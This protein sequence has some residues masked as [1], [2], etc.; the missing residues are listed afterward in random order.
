MPCPFSSAALRLFSCR[1]A[2]CWLAHAL[3]RALAIYHA[4]P[5]LA[6]SNLAT[7]APHMALRAHTSTWR[8]PLAYPISPL[9]APLHGANSRVPLCLAIPHSRGYF[10]RKEY[11]VTIAF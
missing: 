8:A 1:E 10:P 7:A 6:A 2:I 3:P 9:R 4:L 11:S 5:Y